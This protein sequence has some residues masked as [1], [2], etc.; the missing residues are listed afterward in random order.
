MMNELKS[1][2]PPIIRLSLFIVFRFP[3][4]FYNSLRSEM[5]IQC[6]PSLS[7][8]TYR[9]GFEF[10]PARNSLPPTDRSRIGL[11]LRAVCCIDKNARF[12]DDLKRMQGAFQKLSWSLRF[13][14]LKVMMIWL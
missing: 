7:T 8:K 2:R 11:I 12:K 10:T 4:Y 3:R 1:T 5:I 9:R 6:M 14:S 13:V